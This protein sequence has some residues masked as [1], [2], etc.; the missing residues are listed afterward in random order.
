VLTLLLALGLAAPNPS[1]LAGLREEIAHGAVIESNGIADERRYYEP[2]TG[3][4]SYAVHG[5]VPANEWTLQGERARRERVRLALMS[6]VGFYGFAAGPGV[7]IV[8]QHGLGEPL[9]ARIPP[10]YRPDWRIGHVWRE[11][12]EGYWETLRTGADRI[13]DP[14]L[15]Q[16]HAKLALITRGQIWSVERWQAI[17]G[18]ALG[19]YEPLIDVQR[20]RFPPA[21]LLAQAGSAEPPD[22]GGP[23]PLTWL[24]VDVALR[25]PSHARRVELGA[26]GDDAHALVF[27]RG[28]R[29][30]AIAKLPPRPGAGSA[31][32][33]SVADVPREAAEAG[34]DRVRVMPYLGDGRYA[35]GS[36]RLL[37][38]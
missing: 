1:F 12:P 22:A 6:Y 30:L 18:M 16:Y 9:L 5:G 20:Y 31:L 29:D 26:E 32:S 23:A 35:F 8:D 14:G 28:E 27:F 17:L 7:H 13:T 33:T 4:S 15:A 19:R 11:L 2:F 10:P 38:D 34:F 25:E 36:L 37:N 24:G 3:L 21:P